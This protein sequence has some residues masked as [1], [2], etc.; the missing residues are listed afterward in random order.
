MS[1]NKGLLL[2][3]LV[4]IAARFTGVGLNFAL[5]ILIARLLSLGHYGDI[6]MLLTLVIGAALF[7]RLGVEQLMVKEIASV[8]S[9]RQSFGTQFLKK[10]YLVVLG[11][12]AL[13]MLI[14]ITMSSFL[15][16]SFFGEITTTNMM[17]ASTGILFFNLLTI[18]AFYLKALH[19]ASMFTLMQNTLP[20]VTF[21]LLI[22]IFWNSFPHNQLYLNIYTAS[23]VLAGIISIVVILPYLDNNENKST[24]PI[25]NVKN[26]L[27]K[28]IP[29]APV[30]IFSFLML[31]SDTLMVGALL[32]NEKVGLYST[33]AAISFLSLFILGALDS[34]IYPRLLAI[35]KNNPSQLRAF[36]WKATLLVIVGLLLVTLVMGVLAKPALWLFGP[37]F[38]Q[39]LTVLLILLFA[40]WLRATSLTFS[41][42]F[43]IQGKVKYLNSILVIALMINLV[44][45]YTLIH[46]HGMQGAAIATLIAN[47][48]LA[49]FIVLLFF[50]HKL[51]DGYAPNTQPKHSNDA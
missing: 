10:S 13:F 1:A 42:M 7:S 26:L 19:K 35:S 30:S 36:F 24:I 9:N 3:S 41:F 16:K 49:S 39:A 31:W 23:T 15:G 22:G 33:A 45:N 43:I 12:S 21:L 44:A 50:K 37:Q 20:A 11:S 5:Q 40:Q 17:I 8:E 25:P 34:T 48:F 32:D 2:H 47:G 28:S 51:L 38:Q 27:K 6:K 29:L 18:N 14:W 46:S 4:T